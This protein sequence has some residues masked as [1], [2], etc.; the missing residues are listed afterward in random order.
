MMSG[1]YSEQELI[2]HSVERLAQGDGVEAV[3]DGLVGFG[4]ERPE[5]VALVWRARDALEEWRRR[6]S[7]SRLWQGVAMVAL[8]AAVTVGSYLLLDGGYL[9]AVGLVG[10]GL[11]RIFQ[12]IGPP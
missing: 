7:R 1:L 6:E 3:A 4:V 11:Y 5:A 2:Q 8:G 9:I 10:F 12:G